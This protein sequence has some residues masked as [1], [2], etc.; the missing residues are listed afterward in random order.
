VLGRVAWDE[1]AGEVGLMSKMGLTGL[2][3]MSGASLG[4]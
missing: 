2:W 4:R 1:A 3:N